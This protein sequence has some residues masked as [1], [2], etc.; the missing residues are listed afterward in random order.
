MTTPNTIHIIWVGGP[1]QERHA[2]RI[3]QW[4]QLNP[5]YEVC[6]WIEPRLLDEKVLSDLQEWANETKITL[7]ECDKLN[8]EDISELGDAEAIENLRHWISELLDDKIPNYGAVSDL[9]RYLILF[10]EGGWYVD[11]DIIP[12]KPLPT[13]LVLD[14]EFAIDLELDDEQKKVQSHTPGILI[15]N[16]RSQFMSN[17][18]RVILA[19]SKIY[20]T[21]NTRLLSPNLRTREFSTD[22]TTGVLA[23]LAASR[24]LEGGEYFFHCFDELEE[25]VGNVDLCHLISLRKLGLHEYFKI[26]YEGAWLYDE[27]SAPIRGLEKSNIKDFDIQEMR[28]FFGVKNYLTGKLPPRNFA[29]EPR[30]PLNTLSLFALE[31]TEGPNQ[32]DRHQAFT[33]P[34]SP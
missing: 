7:R 19:L 17:A 31:I 6:L 18:V 3:E 26:T 16:A 34:F 1:L 22:I 25:M 14:Y 8:W 4:R 15:S 11:T 9:Y 24:I 29:K 27:E 21:L 23:R 28:F 30:S 32:T 5:D 20:E 13:D 10:S 33:P 2:L 12:E